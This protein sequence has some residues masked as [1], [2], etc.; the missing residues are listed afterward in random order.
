MYILQFLYFYRY[1]LYSGQSYVFE[2]PLLRDCQSFILQSNEYSYYAP[3]NEA[4][5]SISLYN[6]RFKM[7]APLH[8]CHNWFSDHLFYCSVSTQTF[9]FQRKSL[10]KLI[11][12]FL[13]RYLPNSNFMESKWEF[14]IKFMLAQIHQ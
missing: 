8:T 14:V 6:T 10:P 3:N 11:K 7:I 1:G 12:L 4:I 9:V 2:G 13:I 5:A